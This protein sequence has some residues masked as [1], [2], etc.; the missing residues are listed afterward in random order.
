ML[1]PAI[2][3]HSVV[4]VN[5]KTFDGAS[6]QGRIAIGRRLEERSHAQGHKPQSTRKRSVD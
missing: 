4:A 2:I 1:E 5:L 6:F 3:V